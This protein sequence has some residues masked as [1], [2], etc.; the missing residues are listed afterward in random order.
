MFVVVDNRIFH[1]Y[2][3]DC[4]NEQPQEPA[5]QPSIGILL[6]E[7]ARLYTQAQ[8]DQVTS[9][10]DTS[11]TQS[12]VLIELG[13]AGLLTQHELGRRLSLDKGWVS[14]AVDSLVQSVLITKTRHEHDRRSRWLQL[15][16]KGTERYQALN[17][18]LDAHAEQLMQPLAPE[19]RTSIYQAL[20]LLLNGL[21]SALPQEVE[22]VA[23]PLAATDAPQ[24]VATPV[25]AAGSEEPE[26]VPGTST[27]VTEAAVSVAEPEPVAVQPQEEAISQEVAPLAAKAPEPIVADAP[28]EPQAKP[29]IEKRPTSRLG[30]PDAPTRII[31]S[32][33]LP[34]R[35]LLSSR[36]LPRTPLS[37]AAH[38]AEQKNTTP[39]DETPMIPAT[40]ATTHEMPRTPTRPLTVP[41]VSRAQA[42]ATVAAHPAI[43]VQSPSATPAVRPAAITPQI[44]P[45]AAP[46]PEPHVSPASPARQNGS[47]FHKLL[48]QGSLFNKLLQRDQEQ[49][50]VPESEAPPVE[51]EPEDNL[52]FQAAYPS[53]WN[54][55]RNL[56]TANRLP[57]QGALN[58]LSNFVVATENGRVV[59]ALGLE[60][61]GDVGL[62][63]SLVVASNMRG[64][65]IAKRL[66][67]H[68]ILRSREKQ[69]GAL[70]LLAGKTDALFERHGFEKMPRADMPTKL[71]VSMELQGPS[72][73]A[74]TGMRLI[75]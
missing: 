29:A 72:S 11:S 61:Y 44:K 64:R 20:V 58:H 65:S 74:S 51:V 57:V 40:P 31:G 48:S 25:Q 59:G 13:R 69:L 63:R 38:Q 45:V 50:E 17:E 30:Q 68:M 18:A 70:Y 43:K 71:Y 67:K 56:L 23:A 33:T 28:A 27:A 62:L 36:A 42:S 12:H 60:V 21:Q 39:A 6:R 5:M 49:E 46:V 73:T 9:G 37:R 3:V 7:L 26:A 8:R 55:I 22:A 53:D 75:L 10:H 35:P 4:S 47:L 34:I 41:T 66:I 2:R 16:R 14:R 1:L 32:K 19:Q 15:T 52:L 24:L 54:E